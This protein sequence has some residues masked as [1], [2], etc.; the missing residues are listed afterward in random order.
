MSCDL[1]AL[2]ADAVPRLLSDL[3]AGEENLF[4]ER[5]ASTRL[6]KSWHGLH[7]LLTGTSGEGDAPLN[8]LL[9]GGTPLG[10]DPEDFTPQLFAPELVRRIDAALG[11]ISEEELWSRYDAE[12]MEEEM[13]YPNIWDEEE[14]EL[15]EEYLEYFRAM[16]SFVHE[17]SDA[18]RALVVFIR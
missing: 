1:F 12:T 4:R 7:Y 18:G 9:Q 5:S 11:P 13:I 15:R 14:E 17:A 2:P 6:E 3:E 8:F 10:T 16:K